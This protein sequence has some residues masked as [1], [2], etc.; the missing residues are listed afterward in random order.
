[1]VQRL[2]PLPALRAFEA[3]ARRGNLSDA[4]GELLVSHSAISHQI[5]QLQEW[6]GQRLF[7]RTARGLRLTEAGERYKRVVCEAFRQIAVETASLRG[8]E[9]ANVRLSVLPLF[10][11]AWLLPRL[12]DFWARHP[13]IDVTVGY[14][15]FATEVGAERAD[16]T[17]RFGALDQWPDRDGVVLFDGAG[18]PVCSPA[19]REGRRLQRPHDLIGCNLL[20]DGDRSYWME[21]F[22]RQG[23]PA[24]T[25]ERGQVFTD[26]NLTLA[27]TLAGE[28]V[29]ILRRALISRQIRARALVQLFDQAVDEDTCYLLLWPRGQPLRRSA[30]LLRDW[31]VD[32]ATD[33][34]G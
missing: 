4:A 29:A 3:V 24:D 22:R 6:L 13:E 18:V 8:S 16:L 26:G 15:R 12:P 25:A 20:H 10:A 23:M 31:I 34:E 14:T 27:S 21:W 5:K 33:D 11:V 1:M 30:L 7:D 32:R 9:S 19:Y 2:P 17:V 28:G